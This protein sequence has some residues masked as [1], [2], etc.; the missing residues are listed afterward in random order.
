MMLVRAPQIVVRFG[1][2][3]CVGAFRVEEFEGLDQSSDKSLI[4][5]M[6]FT[7][8]EESEGPT[9]GRCAKP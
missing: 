8:R 7:V 4:Y 6:F 5:A 9:A 3:E 1:V 2:S